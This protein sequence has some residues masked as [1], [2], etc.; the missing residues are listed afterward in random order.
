MGIFVTL[1][2]SSIKLIY[3]FIFADLEFVVFVFLSRP[4]YFLRLY[5]N[6]HLKKELG[7]CFRSLNSS[8]I[9]KKFV[10]FFFV[11]LKLQNYRSLLQSVNLMFLCLKFHV[12]KWETTLAIKKNQSSSSNISAFSSKVVARAQSRLPNSQMCVAI[13]ALFSTRN[14]QHENESFI[15]K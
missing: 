1:D 14:V 2:F 3:L 8:K 7:T 4:M 9:V 12:Q 10:I 11:F 5:A 15:V 6:F 13:I